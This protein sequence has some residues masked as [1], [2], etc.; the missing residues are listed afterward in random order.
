MGLASSQ[1]RDGLFFNRPDL[2]KRQQKSIKNILIKCK[3]VIVS[4]KLLFY[5]RK[6]RFFNMTSRPVGNSHLPAE[7][8]TIPENVKTGLKISLFFASDG[9]YEDR[10][11]RFEIWFFDWKWRRT[12][13]TSHPF[14]ESHFFLSKVE[15]HGWQSS[16]PVWQSHFSTGRDE[17]K[18]GTSG[19]DGNASRPVE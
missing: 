19:H 9:V 13:K 18:I 7:S 16:L 3:H 5:Y 12:G 1:H 15:H 10:Y 14:W 11:F 4:L 17:Q 2:C 6:W 8:S